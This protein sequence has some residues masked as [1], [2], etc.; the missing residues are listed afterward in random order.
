MVQR[1]SLNEVTVVFDLDGT[2]VDTAPDLVAALN[3]SLELAGFSRVRA[4]IV[5]GQIGLGSMAMI[6][7]GLA[8]QGVEV[9]APEMADIRA[10][11][12]DHYAANTANHSAPY[13]GVLDTLA[14][15]RDHGAALAVCTNKPQNLADTLLDQLQMKGWFETVL[16][17]DSVPNP[18]PHP[19]HILKTIALANGN[20]KRAIMIGDS[21]PDEE[22]A[23]RAGLPFL[24][25][26]FGYGPI[27]PA[28]NG[29]A[30]FTSYGQ[31]TPSFIL[32]FL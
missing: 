16:G 1:A 18:K 14:T 20:A 15:L 7:K 32:G 24:F 4:E 9:D 5:Q 25:V 6:Q 26:P 28:Q 31:L 22:A 3:I 13:P 10:V 11:F 2:L 8:H 29:R 27:S 17:S 19:D 21:T 30:E 23:R 12:L